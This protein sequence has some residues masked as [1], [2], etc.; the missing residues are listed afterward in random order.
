[1][2]EEFISQVLLEINGQSITDFKSVEEKDYELHK[3]V[4]LMGR[5]GHIRA[6]PR[7][8]VSVE[9][10]KPSDATPFDF[11]QVRGGTLTID[12]ENG[13]RIKYTGLYVTNIG[14]VKYDGENEASQTIDFSAVKRN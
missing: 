10:V 13:T 6:T 7:Y 12:Y 8:G 9:Y 3:P 11:T 2:S 4:L 5:T 14:A 1:M